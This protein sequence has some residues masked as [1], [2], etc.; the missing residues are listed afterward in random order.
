V[1]A[2]ANRRD[3]LRAGALAAGAL[4]LG[5]LVNPLRAAAQATS[6]EAEALRDF[7]AEAVAREQITALAYAEA[8][9]SGG[10]DA[11]LE[12]TLERFRTQTQAHVNALESALES[13]GFDASDTPSDPADDGVFDGVD[14]IDSETATEL[15]ELLATV[16]EPTN[17]KGY[18]DLLIDLEL[19]EIRFYVDRAP[20]LDSE[21][22]RTTC[23]EIAGNQAQHLVAL[24]RANDVA[25]A[26]ALQVETGAGGAEGS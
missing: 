9:Q 16:G 19:G 18:L 25:L 5:G 4:A 22:L 1:N 7:L 23:A 3:A 20:T 8:G 17:L 10:L 15:G 14:G 13:L 21:D 6:E 24:R 26:E 11:D 12:G 2:P